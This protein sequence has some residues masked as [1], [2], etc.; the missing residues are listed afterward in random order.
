[1]R[2]A[3]QASALASNDVA[4]AGE[5][6]DARPHAPDITG[7]EYWSGACAVATA[8]LIFILYAASRGLG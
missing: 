1:M 8:W 3:V 2:C 5:S 7:A 6:H 4:L